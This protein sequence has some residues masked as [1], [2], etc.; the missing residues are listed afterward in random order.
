MKRL[1]LKLLALI[2]VLVASSANLQAQD[3]TAETFTYSPANSLKLTRFG[4]AGDTAKA[5]PVII[6][7]FGGGF[8]HG[9]RLDARYQP[10]FDFMVRHG[11][12]VCTIDYRTL[13]KDFKPSGENAALS[14]GTQLVAAVTAATEDFV[15]ATAYIAGNAADFRI[16]PSKMIASGS[17]AGAIAALEAVYTLSSSTVIPIRYR[18]AVTF[19][20][21]LLTEGEPKLGTELCP[22]MLFQGDADNQVPYDSLVLGPI[23]LYGSH[24]LASHLK[25]A[26]A[27]GA[28][29]TELGATHDMA[30]RPMTENLYDIAGFLHHVLNGGQRQYDWTEVTVPGRAPYRTDFTITDYIRANMP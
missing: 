20:G 27:S 22:M 18:A 19:A 13:L 29:W 17:S 6:F 21:A 24:Y 10:Y 14:F 5:R 9:D 3:I 16:D 2:M 11:Y 23:G 30:L 4:L 8:S 26:G 12:V 1:T 7:A 15:T 28:F 25:A